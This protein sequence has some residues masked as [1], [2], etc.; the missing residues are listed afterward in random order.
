MF[1]VEM[2]V[3]IP[4]ERLGNLTLSEGDALVDITIGFYKQEEVS[5]GHAA[6][7]AGLSSLRFLEELARR[8]IPI[9]YDAED[10]RAD[11]TTLKALS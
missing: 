6:E 2:T 1:A 9:N 10:L 7:I 8:R 3:T 4:A 11:T 5:L